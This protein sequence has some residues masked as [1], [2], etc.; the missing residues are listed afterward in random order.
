MFEN[1]LLLFIRG[2]PSTPSAASSCQEMERLLLSSMSVIS[3]NPMKTAS[4]STPSLENVGLNGC[5]PATATGY[6]PG[7]G[8]LTTSGYTQPGLG[9]LLA[10]TRPVGVPWFSSQTF[11]PMSRAMPSSHHRPSVAV[12]MAQ[13]ISSSCHG[14]SLSRSST[15]PSLQH[16]QSASSPQS[17]LSYM[18][19]SQQSMPISRVVASSGIAAP[20]TSGV[21]QPARSSSLVG[22]PTAQNGLAAM[23]AAHQAGR[24]RDPGRQLKAPTS[25]RSD[26]IGSES[27]WKLPPSHGTSA[28]VVATSSKDLMH[29]T[30]CGSA[31]RAMHDL[32]RG[33][34][35]WTV[36]DVCS[37]LAANDCQ[38]F[39]DIFKSN[40]SF[41]EAFCVNSLILVLFKSVLVLWYL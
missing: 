40:V 22:M 16:L 29:E 35:S 7:G 39:C 4:F 3:G 28:A 8:G 27:K 20:M 11:G 32:P 19:F 36:S 25:I 38:S 33:L 30:V 23:A 18:P 26:T 31:M 13:C 34:E 9:S 21:V 1:G 37:F 6:Q 5:A 2:T 10:N 41:V 15:V 14:V 17:A 24:F 12:A